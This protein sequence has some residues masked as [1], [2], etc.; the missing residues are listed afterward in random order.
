MERMPR[1]RF[2]V[3][4]LLA[5]CAPQMVAAENRPWTALLMLDDM[6]TVQIVAGS[7]AVCMA[8]VEAIISEYR[9]VT[10][11][12]PCLPSSEPSAIT[13]DNGYV[14]RTRRSKSPAPLPSGGGGGGGSSGGGA[15]GG[16]VG[17]R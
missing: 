5:G 13:D 7:E 12:E 1:Y 9:S 2:M 17:G 8:E 16:G 11:I 14:R 6:D 15:G 3:V 4:F 10:M